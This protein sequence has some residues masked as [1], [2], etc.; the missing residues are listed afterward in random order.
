MVFHVLST[1]LGTWC[2][3]SAMLRP[4]RPISGELTHLMIAGSVLIRLRF[5][6]VRNPGQSSHFHPHSRYVYLIQVQGNFGVRFSFGNLSR[7]YKRS[8]Q[9]IYVTA[10]QWL[11][12]F[13]ISN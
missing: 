9:G 2:G 12:V 7:P 5:F 3:T 11:V 6:I 4:W 8:L 13:G 1:V 10:I